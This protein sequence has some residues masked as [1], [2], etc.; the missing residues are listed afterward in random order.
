MSKSI[1]LPVKCAQ[2]ACTH[3]ENKGTGQMVCRIKLCFGH[4]ANPKRM[5]VCECVR[6]CVC[7]FTI[8]MDF[9]RWRWETRTTGNS[10]FQMVK[11]CHTELVAN[12][13]ENMR[14]NG[15]SVQLQFV[16]FVSQALAAAKAAPAHRQRLHFT[17]NCEWVL[18]VTDRRRHVRCR[19]KI[20]FDEIAIAACNGT[21]NA[22]CHKWFS[23]PKF[24][25]VACR[26]RS[27]PDVRHIY[28]L[29]H[30]HGRIWSA[31]KTHCPDRWCRP[32]SNWQR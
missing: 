13:N 23:V 25:S 5:W 12:L 19:I 32:P 30:T 2:Q 4:S 9:D 17:R 7:S 18:C 8:L 16:L 6:M 26:Y 21:D 11:W 27:S 3:A 28:T 1:H 31:R 15:F 14:R 10:T 20:T 22:H 24:I 29:I